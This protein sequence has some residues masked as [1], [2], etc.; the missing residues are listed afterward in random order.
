MG[1]GWGDGE[2]E[3]PLQIL[4][5]RQGLGTLAMSIGNESKLKMILAH[6]L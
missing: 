4:F 1:Q 6:S 2:R 5:K 3:V